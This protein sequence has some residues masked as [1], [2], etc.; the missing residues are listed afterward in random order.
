MGDVIA[1]FDVDGTLTVRDCVVPFLIRVAG[2]RSRLAMRLA[3]HP[4]GLL[5]IGVRRDRDL[6]KAAASR[7][8]FSGQPHDRVLDEGRAFAGIVAA[9]WLR[10]DTSARL[11][12]HLD[13]GH[14]V[15]LVSASYEVY[16]TPLGS[17][18]GVADVLGTRLAVAADGTCTGE[19]DG[20]NCRAGEKVT[21]VR[22]WQARRG[23]EGAEIWA[24]G[25]SAGDD[26]MLRI[27][28]H[29]V[30]ITEAPITTM[31]GVV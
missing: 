29:P 3:A 1:A 13:Q 31:P 26:E 9:S 5:R 14:H 28:D 18:L 2:N 12:W 11:G 20:P 30:R 22:E 7:A 21:R 15:V 6:A 17:G 24:Y 23:L 10:P 8:A 27:A 25:D 4:V 19:L 16:L